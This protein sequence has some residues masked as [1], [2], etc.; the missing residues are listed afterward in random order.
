MRKSPAFLAAAL[1]GFACWHGE[2]DEQG[3]ASFAES[4][5]QTDTRVNTYLREKLD[6]P[7]L[8][9]CWSHLTGKGVVGVELRYRRQGADWAFEGAQPR[10]AKG[11]E[12][13][14][15]AAAACLAEAAR[16]T[17]FPVAPQN[18]TENDAKEFFVRWGFEVPLPN[19]AD[20]VTA[21]IIDQPGDP[22]PEPVICQDCVLQ[23]GVYSCKTRKRGY[24]DCRTYPDQP[25]VCSTEST[26]CASGVFGVSGGV[27]MY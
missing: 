18:G 3:K 4:E 22:L 7:A 24:P 17:A 11:A 8:R 2:P 16:G 14:E 13:Q 12:G 9:A 5:A 23:N 6:T 21:M 26:A 10:G 1:V 15:E 20:D 27:V 25:N 19:S